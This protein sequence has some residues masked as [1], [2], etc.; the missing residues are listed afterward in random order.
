MNLS[1]KVRSIIR[2]EDLIRPGDRVLAALSGGIDSTALFSILLEAAEDLP[3]ELAVAH[4]NHG[5]RKDESARDERFVRDLAAR[6]AIPVHV[7]TPDVRGYARE[8]GLSLQHAGRDLRYGFFD[9]LVQEYGYDAVVVAHNLDDQVETFLARLIK[10]TGIRGLS[11]MPFRRGKI[12]RPF[13]S[14]SRE[15]I[16][17]FVE[18]R[19]IAFVEDSSNRKTAYERNYIRR[20]LIPAME[21]LNPRVKEKIILLLE[22]LVGINRAFDERAERF[23]EGECRQE[24]SRVLLDSKAFA[25]LDPE[26]AYRVG[27]RLLGL[28]DP[29]FIPLRDHILL[30]RRLASGVRPNSAVTLPGGIRAKRMYGELLFTKEQDQEIIGDIVPVVMG[31]NRLDPFGMSLHVSEGGE[32]ARRFSDDPWTACFD[33]GKI[34]SLSVRTFREGDR[35]QPLGMSVPVKLKDFFIARKVPREERRRIPL[36]LS[37]EDIIWVVGCRIDERYKVEPSTSRFITVTVR[38]GQETAGDLSTR[39]TF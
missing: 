29:S 4:V 10:G 20:N 1:G 9:R 23:L 13:L 7:L 3:F 14:T 33:G 5:L 30:V 15:E 11:A 18:A 26:T 34:G 35:F 22:D 31:E 2:K 36:L 24:G 28:L 17:R 32:R 6:H 25:R 16:V 27:A 21:R 39:P 37:G 12:V 19:G 8:A 38:P